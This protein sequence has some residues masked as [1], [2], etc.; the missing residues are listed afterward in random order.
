MSLLQEIKALRDKALKT[1]ETR[2]LGSYELTR[3]A[4]NNL[5]VRWGDGYEIRIPVINFRPYQREIRDELVNQHSK[6]ILAQWPR[7]SGKEVT[8]W[9]IILDFA[10]SEPGMYL[11]VYPTNV[12][13]RKI[14]WE[15]AMLNKETG[16]SIKFVEMLPKRLL[17][18][19]PNDQDMSLHLTNGSLIWVV[20]CDIDPEK[21]RG[22]NP[23]GIVFSELAFSDPRVLYNMLPVLRQNGGWLFGQSTYDGMNH[24]YY[25][26]KKNQ[27]DPLWFCKDESI[28]TLVDEEGK[29]YITDEDV[30][31]DRRAG[32]PEYLI[33]QEYYG[34]VQINEETKYFAIAI[35]A[36][37]QTDRII[38]NHY[39]PNKAVYAFY[40]IGVSDYTAITLA[41]F[42][43]RAGKLWPSV[44]GYIENNNRALS[45][46]VDEV[47]RF[48][49]MRNLVLKTHFIPHDGANRNFGD[50][51]KT[52]QD[53][54]FEMGQQAVIV[55]RPSTHKVAIEAIRQKLY[56]TTFNQ[57]NTQR[58]IDCLSNYEKEFDAKMGK[59]KDNP[60]H[61]WSSHGV[62]SYQTLVLAL[63]SELITEVSYDVIYYDQTN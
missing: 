35:N 45:F 58:L 57:E 60:K 63:E 9:N 37:H 4:A 25:M 49:N 50:G 21:L 6:R 52:T 1:H 5:Q 39:I 31:E 16:E 33:Q 40:D 23:R 48:C 24:F 61:D 20:G 3:D 55:K 2:S 41:Q 34:N 42:D 18:K 7:R 47:N 51:L 62:K 46:Y 11:M 44:I 56:M 8:T 54:L 13:A 59:F 30:D 28:N 26:L 36:V 32:M 22:T 19:R 12:R 15:G 17:S 38:A 10:I 53:Y 14:L 43:T 29:P 27:D